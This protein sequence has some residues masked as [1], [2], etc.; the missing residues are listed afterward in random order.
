MSH[1][2]KLHEALVFSAQADEAWEWVT[3]GD[4]TSVSQAWGP[5]PGVVAVRDEPPGFFDEPGHSRILE[6][7]DGSTV[8]ETIEALDPPR[9]IDYAVSELTNSF[10]HVTSGAKASFQFEPIDDS[11]TRVTW[12][13]SW[14]ARNAASLP[15]VWLVAHGAFRP[16]MRRMLRRMGRSR[17]L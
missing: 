16:Y 13:Y 4:L 3:Q 7:S 6:N 2:V 5:I 9:R 11:R 15:L 10:R 12:L 14:E 17:V 8:I 1:F